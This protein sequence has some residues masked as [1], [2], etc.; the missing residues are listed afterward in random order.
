MN[1]ILLTFLLI[2]TLPAC[3]PTSYD[4]PQTNSNFSGHQLID[5]D[6][7]VCQTF[8]ALLDH[9]NIK[10]DGTLNSIANITQKQWLRKPGFERWQVQ[11]IQDI[12][13]EAITP[14][15]E[16]FE[17]LHEWIQPI[18]TYDYILIFGGMVSRVRRRIA[19]LAHLWQLGVRSHSVIFLTGERPLDPE[20]ENEKT[21]TD[22]Q[23]TDFP[24]RNNWIAPKEL[25]TTEN[26]MVMYV[27]NQ[28]A[29]PKELQKI[30]PTIISVPMIKT[31]ANNVRRPSTRDTL[32]TWLNTNPTPGT[33]LIISNQPYIGYQC[34]VARGILPESF[35]I[36]PTGGCVHNI[37]ET[38]VSVYLDTLARQFYEEKLNFDKMKSIN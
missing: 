37:K 2:L 38:P 11:D 5:K 34:T 24:I 19:H 1:K 12:E 18:K 26:A 22:R 17:L 32:I 35:K 7:T 14:Y 16:K 29:L 3:T 21:L 23:N 30:T 33:C 8:L 31:D 27:F 9:M 36:F 10:H 20:I 28:L 25:P 4:Q 6:G 15:L 13:Y